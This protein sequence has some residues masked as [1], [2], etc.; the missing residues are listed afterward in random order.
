MRDVARA[1]A[2]GIESESQPWTLTPD[3]FFTRS[4][5]LRE[6][7]ARLIG[8]TADDVAIV[9]SV[10]YAISTAARNIALER[11]DEIVVLDEQ[12]PSNVYPWRERAR[13]CGA[14]LR[15]VA[16]PADDDWTVAVVAS[17]TKRCA[18]VSIPAVHWAYGTLIDLVAVR[19]AADAVGAKLV[20]D[21]AQSLGALPFDVRE[22][23]PDFMACPT[24]KWLL[25]PYAMGF[26]YAAP[27][28][29]QGRPI[30]QGW[31]TRRGSEDFAHLVDYQDEFQPGARRY[32]MGERAQFTLAP[33][34]ETA[35]E[36]LLGWGVDAI[37]SEL[38]LRN[39]AI[40][41][42]AAD[43]GFIAVPDAL[44]AG[45]YLGLRHTDGLDAEIVPKLAAR[46]VYVSRR[47]DCL[48]ITQHL[49]NNDNDVDR[50]FAAL[51]SL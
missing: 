32:D 10:S 49:Y 29:Q 44:R 27:H 37:Y 16:V 35:L 5:R 48:R 25:G 24:Y 4:E 30:E 8:A 22:V 33:M 40:V 50:L 28:F 17:I 11:G 2:A 42:R 47:G 51:G 14:E 9:P 15:T 18:V 43:I 21:L 3:G 45:H 34:V 46:G 13:E 1:G 26:L 20:L 39:R 23:R 36:R 7:F 41:E 38:S 12:F 31:I 6:L 19:R